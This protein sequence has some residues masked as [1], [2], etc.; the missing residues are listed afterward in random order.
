MA[1][2]SPTRSV[3]LRLKSL[4]SPPPQAHISLQAAKLLLRSFPNSEEI[5]CTVDRHYR[6]R[7][8]DFPHARPNMPLPHHMILGSPS[9]QASIVCELEAY[10]M[11][12]RSKRRPNCEGTPFSGRLG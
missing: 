4:T 11:K 6:T 7:I 12:T 3:K 8:F 5:S 2:R 9:V 10:F 1:N